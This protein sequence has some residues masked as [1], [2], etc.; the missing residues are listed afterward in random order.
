MTPATR[1]VAVKPS[2]QEDDGE[3]VSEEQDGDKHQPRLH[4]QEN[5]GLFFLFLLSGSHRV[6][7]N[8]DGEGGDAKGT[9][10]GAGGPATG[11][12]CGLVR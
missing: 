11:M 3:D 1:G 5:L 7:A 6:L 2:K 4:S 8:G 10:D 12:V 9:V